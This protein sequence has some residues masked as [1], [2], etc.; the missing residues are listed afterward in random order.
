MKKVYGAFI[1]LA[2][3]ISMA[4]AEYSVSQKTADSI[5]LYTEKVTDAIQNDESSVNRICDDMHQTWHEKQKILTLFLPQGDLLDIDILAD[6]ALIYAGT[7]DKQNLLV[8]LAEI[9]NKM[10]SLR[11]SE[12]ISIY[13][14]L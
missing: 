5:I 1:I 7:N 6:D 4:Y 8:T 2:V 3:I 14:L 10:K 12:E 13:N 11:T 9:N